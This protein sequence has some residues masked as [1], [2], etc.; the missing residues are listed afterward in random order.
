MLVACLLVFP[1]RLHA[2]NKSPTVV[3]FSNSFSE[4]S[5]D[6]LIKGWEILVN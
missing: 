5:L 6:G 1:Y 3:V 2:E 4:V